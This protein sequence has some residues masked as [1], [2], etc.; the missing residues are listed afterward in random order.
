MIYSSSN[1]TFKKKIILSIYVL[2]SLIVLSRYFKLQISEY[3]KYKLLGEKNSIVARELTAPRGIIYDTDSLSIVDNKFIY[4]L[5]IIPQHF[6]KNKFN[7]DILYK[8]LKIE[9]TYINSIID[10]VNKTSYKNQPQLI[11]RHIDFQ[12][13]SLLDENKLD[14]KGMYFSKSPIRTFSDKCN[15]SHVVGYLRQDKNNKKIMAMSGIEKKYDNILTGKDGV[16]YHLVDSKG[17]D[18]GMVSEK[19][20]DRD[21]KPTQGKNLYLSINLHLQEFCEK[22]IDENQKGS[23]IVSNPNTGEILA[24]FSFPDYDLNSFSGP[25]SNKDWKNLNQQSVFIN[26]SVESKYAPGSIFKLILASIALEK[27]IISV[28][29]KVNCTGTYDFYDTKFHCWNKD[30]HGIVD[31]KESIQKSCNIYYYNLIQKMGLDF[32]AEEIKKFGLGKKTNIDLLIEETGLVPTRKFMNDYF[33]DKGGWSTGHLLNLSIGQGEILV[34]PIQINSL[35]SIICN[36]GYAFTPHINKNIDT[37]MKY[38]AYENSVWSFI[39]KSMYDAV[40]KSGGTAYNAKIE[41]TKGD[42]YGKTGTVQICSDCD[43]LPHAWFAGF[44]ETDNNNYALTII[45]ENGGKG[46]NIPSKMAKTIFEF[47]VDNDI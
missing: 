13:K 12:T 26:R 11:K 3:D 20:N 1:K 7:Y 46:S 18:Q 37:S 17:I 28:N 14:L 29:D 10:S 47:I 23:I 15:L 21:F 43:I 41:K 36:S 38:V 31:I 19:F 24:M 40:N 32:W 8:L 34:T 22:L 6:D 45:I 33:K 44:L 35:V 42:V 30:G 2:F 5:N 27:N 4:D 25:I 39:R 16:E 9:K